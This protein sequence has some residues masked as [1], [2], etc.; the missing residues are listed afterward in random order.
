MKPQRIYLISLLAWLGVVAIDA[1]VY[2]SGVFATAPGSE[3][4]ANTIGFQLIAYA[5]TR[6]IY[7]VVALVCV[8]LVEFTLFGRKPQAH[9]PQA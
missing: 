5:L 9:G 2:L 3:V 1:A 6:G 7:F 4:Y 8:L